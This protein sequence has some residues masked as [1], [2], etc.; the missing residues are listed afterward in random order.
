MVYYSGIILYWKGGKT[1]HYVCA[2]AM[3]HDLITT[4]KYSNCNEMGKLYTDICK[5]NYIRYTFP[6]SFQSS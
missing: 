1:L 6:Y 4:K 3:E 2:V 5:S